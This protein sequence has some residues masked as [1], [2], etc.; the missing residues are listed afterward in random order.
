MVLEGV[1]DGVVS[2]EVDSTVVE[3]WVETLEEVEVEVVTEELVDSTVVDSLVVPETEVLTGVGV[4][5]ALAEAGIGVVAVDAMAVLGTT[6]LE[7]GGTPG[8]MVTKRLV[9]LAV[10]GVGVL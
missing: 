10:Y 1:A 5:L 3:V 6:T 4:E 7:A 2:V 8:V 9:S